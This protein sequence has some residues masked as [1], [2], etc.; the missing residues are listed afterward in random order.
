MTWLLTAAALT[1][2]LTFAI[3]WQADGSADQLRHALR[4][5]AWNGLSAPMLLAIFYPLIWRRQ[6]GAAIRTPG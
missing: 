3:T 2:T 5:T 6:S 4:L 1:A